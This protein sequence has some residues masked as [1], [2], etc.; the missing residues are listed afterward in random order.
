MTWISQDFLKHRDSTIPAFVAYPA[1]RNGRNQAD[2]LE[3]F[4]ALDLVQ[5]M[6]DQ[7]DLYAQR[8]IATELP[9]PRTKHPRRVQWRPVKMS[10]VADIYWTRSQIQTGMVTHYTRHTPHSIICIASGPLRIET[11]IVST[12]FCSG[13]S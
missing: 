9:K 3:Q 4:I 6:V 5:T 11:Q 10:R 13:H 12:E 8:Q 2:Y 7:T 1:F